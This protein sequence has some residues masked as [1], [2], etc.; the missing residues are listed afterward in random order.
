M[1][2]RVRSLVFLPVA[3]VLAGLLLWGLAGMPDFG[4]AH[5]G[6]FA[7][8]VALQATTQRHVTNVPS[9]VVFDY[10]G[11]DTLGEELIL[12]T[13]VMGVALLLRS[14]RSAEERAP[15]DRL[16]GGPQRRLGVLAVPVTLLLGVWLVTYGYLTPGGGFQGGVVCGAAALL[17]WAVGSYRDHLAL[18]P[19]ALVDAAEGFGAAAYVTVGVGALVAGQAYLA[20]F[21]PLDGIGTLTSGGTIIVLNWATGLEV[22]AA[23]VLVLREFLKEYVQSLPHARKS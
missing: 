12:F 7:R 2:A 15:V 6:Y 14:S 20:N 16:A 18:T 11:V 13:C 8:A 19:T 21:L 22:A 3:A 17:V 9:A 23:T 1:T 10:R 5:P 4:T